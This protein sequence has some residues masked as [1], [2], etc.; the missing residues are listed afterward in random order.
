[1]LEHDQENNG[2]EALDANSPRHSKSIPIPRFRPLRGV[3]PQ[4]QPKYGRRR[5]PSGGAIQ[6]KIHASATCLLCGEYGGLQ[7]RIDH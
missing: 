4:Q 6:I 7:G 3:S 1:M 5:F 2:N